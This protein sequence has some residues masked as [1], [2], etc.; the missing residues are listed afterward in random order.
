[1]RLRAHGEIES[2]TTQSLVKSY[3]NDMEVPND[4]IDYK[5]IVSLIT[6][7]LQKLRQVTLPLPPPFSALFYLFFVTTHYA[8]AT[9]CQARFSS[10]FYI[11]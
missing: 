8:P 1:V 4:H 3:S 10:H 7:D 11:G 5:K 6:N 2:S 9:Y